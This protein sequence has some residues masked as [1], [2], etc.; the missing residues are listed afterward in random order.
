M[1]AFPVNIDVAPKSMPW[2]TKGCHAS[3]T[4]WASSTVGSVGAS[5][6]AFRSS[7]VAGKKGAT[8]GVS[9][10]SGTSPNCLWVARR[11]MDV[12]VGRNK[13]RRK[14]DR[15]LL[16]LLLVMCGKQ[17]WMG[18]EIFACEELNPAVLTLACK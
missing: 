4:D 5:F 11:W 14:I 2:G 10:A 6:A 9:G 16:F 8:S 18:Q 1:N 13:R 3:P 15:R 12:A 17:I 7:F